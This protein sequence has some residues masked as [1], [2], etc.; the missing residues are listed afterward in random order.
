M[1]NYGNFKILPSNHLN[2]K[3]MFWLLIDYGKVID[4]NIIKWSLNKQISEIHGDKYDYSKVN[5]SHINNKIKII[6]NEHGE[7]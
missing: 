2:N 4:N 6:C 3:G 5:H 7:F 1:S